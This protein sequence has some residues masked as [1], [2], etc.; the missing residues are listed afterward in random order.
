MYFLAIYNLWSI[1]R[2]RRSLRLHLEPWEHIPEQG[3]PWLQ[4]EIKSYAYSYVIL[5][6]YI[7]HCQSNAGGNSIPVKLNMPS[8]NIVLIVELVLESWWTWKS[9]IILHRCRVDLKCYLLSYRTLPRH[10]SLPYMKCQGPKPTFGV[11]QKFQT[12]NF[13]TKVRLFES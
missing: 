1:F 8:W 6:F 4:G 3:G 12:W 2:K 7:F 11:Y 13:G 9:W 10:P 5:C